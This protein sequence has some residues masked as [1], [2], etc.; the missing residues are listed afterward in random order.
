MN[1]PL[2]KSL[3]LSLCFLTLLEN[4]ICA[5]P[6][7]PILFTKIDHTDGLPNNTI[8]G[9]VK[10]DLGF[11]WIATNDGLC[12]YESS[13]DLKIYR[14]NDPVVEGGL[15]SSNIRALFL[16]RKNN[17]WIGTRLGGLTRLHQPSGTWTT[18]RHDKNDP[19]SISNDEILVITEDSKGRLWVG[20]ENGLNLFQ[21]ETASFI[22][23]KSDLNDPAALKGKAVLTIMEDEKGWIW[24][25]TWDGGINL[26]LLPSDGN[27]EQATFRVFVPNEKNESKHIWKLYQ[28]HQDRIWVGSRGAGLFLMHLPLEATNQLGAQFWKPRFDNYYSGKEK[29]GIRSDHLQDIYQ[30]TKGN[31]WFATANGLHCIFADELINAFQSNTL[32]KRPEFIFHHY[33]YELNNPDALTNSDVSTIFEDGQGLL[34]FGT[35]SGINLYNKYTNQFEFQGLVDEISNVPNSQN[36]YID[37]KG[38]LWFGNGASG[39]IKYDL[40]K[41]EKVDLLKLGEH[42]LKNVTALFSPDNRYLYIGTSNG[43]VVLDMT[44]NKTKHY[45]LPSWIKEKINLLNIRSLLKDQQGRIWIGSEV[46]LLVVDERTGIYTHYTHQPDNPSSISDNPINQIYQDSNGDIWVATFNGLNRVRSNTSDTIE[47]EV[48]KHDSSNLENSISSNRTVAL[49]EID[50]Y[51]Y[52]GSSDGLSAFDLKEKKFINYSKNANKTSIQS[53]EKTI[54][55][56]VWASTTE[57]ILFFNTTTHV[58]NQY[59]KRDGLKDI[60]FLACSSDRDQDGF[61]Y[62]G[63]RQGITRF[64]PKQLISNE[65]PPS[66]Y[67]TKIRKMSPDGEITTNGIYKNEIIVSHNEYYLSLDFTALNYNRSEKNQYAFKLEGFEKNWNYTDKKTPAVYT[68]LAPGKY[69]FRV[70]AANND[71]IWNER[72]TILTIIKKP[73]FWQSWW[74]KL[75]VVFL[76]ILLLVGGMKYYTRN[77]KQRNVTLQRYNNNL[78]KEISHRKIVEAALQEREQHMEL[79][80]RHRTKELEIKNEEVK[81]LLK[82]IKERN[83]HL[84]IQITHRTQNLRDSNEKLQRSNKDLEQFTFIASHDLQEPLRVVGNFIGLL[85]RRYKQYFDEEAFQYIDFAMNGVSRMSQQIKNILTFSSISQNIFNFQPTDLNQIIDIKLQELARIIEVRSVSFNIDKMPKISCEKSQIAMVFYNLINNAIKFNKNTN[86]TITISNLTKETDDFWHF[87]V[88]DN[89]IGID[90]KYQEK[91]FKIFKRL[92]SKKEYEGTGIGLALCE[93]II[94]QH[95]GRIWIKSDEGAGAT[96]HFTISKAL[97]T[98][99]NLTEIVDKPRLNN[100][101]EAESN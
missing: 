44:T 35:Y 28:D 21:E 77:I 85:K 90:K 56:N 71:G 8:N 72:G 14:A 17:L 24:V 30:D 32:D 74:F 47:F 96:F 70:K 92:H 68:N 31:L 64:H 6:T 55:G 18:F 82:D 62:F 89:G 13:N 53:L 63:N 88:V 76:S 80:V 11:I 46:G 39:I 73:A 97:N 78:N 87:A 16:D 84:E 36:L 12:R 61:L 40:E 4:P 69:Q 54:D 48:F 94:H 26:L 57:G 60:V 83:D 3:V 1:H 5:Q 50:Q 9:I 19:T 38:V 15:E 37:L 95:H 20:T 33:G 81:S 75:L 79:L 23:F 49:V 25:G 91:V 98:K 101:S 100:L 22:S 43:V 93:K 10:D 99:K 34:W 51:L 52:I 66:V 67:V 59:E 42:L 2:F 29:H 86:P 65:Q 27:V 58:F 41:K 45:P 7:H